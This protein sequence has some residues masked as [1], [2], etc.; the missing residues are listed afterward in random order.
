M[1]ALD[2]LLGAEDDGDGLVFRVLAEEQDGLVFAADRAGGAALEVN[3]AAEDLFRAL[4]QRTGSVDLAHGAFAELL[5][6]QINVRRVAP[7]GEVA[8]VGAQRRAIARKGDL[9]VGVNSAVAE[10][11]GDKVELRVFGELRAQLV[12]QHRAP[13]GIQKLHDA[14]VRALRRCEPELRGK[15]LRGG[16]DLKDGQLRARLGG[17]GIDAAAVG[18]AAVRSLDAERGVFSGNGGEAL[19]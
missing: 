11:E 1:A 4:H 6:G 12:A 3:G 19:A 7:A 15:G 16:A 9:V 18:R 10:L 13:R 14:K 5:N 2:V 17:H 8:E